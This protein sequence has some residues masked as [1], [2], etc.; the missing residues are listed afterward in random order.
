MFDLMIPEAKLFL[1][2]LPFLIWFTL[3]FC[4]GV[5]ERYPEVLDREEPDAEENTEEA[6]EGLEDAEERY[7]RRSPDD[8][9]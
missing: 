8:L 5:T 2:A 4:F 1:F 9:W 3:L 7:L 6:D